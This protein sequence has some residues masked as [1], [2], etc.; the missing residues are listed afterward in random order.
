MSRT[1]PKTCSEC[2]ETEG[3]ALGHTWVDVTCAEPKHCSVCGETEGEALEHTWT[4]ANYQQ[5]A[6]CEVCG[7]TEGEPLV[8]SFE[9]CGL[10]INVEEG[11]TYDYVTCGYKDKSKEVIGH[12]VFSDYRIVEEDT[13]L[14]LEK[15][16]GYEWRIVHI[17]VL[18]D[19]ENANNYGM[20][21]GHGI[22]DYYDSEDW[23]EGKRKDENTGRSYSTVNYNGTQYECC[24][25]FELNW[26]DWIGRESTDEINYCVNVPIGY[27]GI[28][29]YLYNA[30]NWE[31]GML[32]SECVDE[33]TLFF[34]MD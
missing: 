7:E 2:G 29:V 27:D 20:S 1:E 16:E 14:G 8:A 3:E 10:T 17:S 6:T 21:L 12:A 31:E 13:E 25:I 9:E 30:K 24:Y 18:Y 23:N 28:L 26:S 4:E 19:D 22:T 34:R 5:P 11:N 33:D 32:D 15:K